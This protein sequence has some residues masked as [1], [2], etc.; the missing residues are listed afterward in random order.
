M[1]GILTETAAH[2][3]ATPRVYDPANFPER[4]GNGIPV[5]E[6][7]VFYQRPWMGGRWGV[8]EA[9]DYMMTVDFAILDTAVARRENLLRKAWE[10]A[11][12]NI[13]AGSEGGPFA[14][15]VPETGN[16][17]EMLQRLRLAGVEVRR[18]TQ[19]FT[20]NGKSFASGTWVIPAAQAFRGYIVDLMEPQRYPELRAGITGPTKK[21]YDVAGWTLPMLMG[22]GYERV[23]KPFPAALDSAEPAPVS[24]TPFSGRKWPRIALYQPWQPNMDT[25]WTQWVFDRLQIPYTLV[26]N[27]DVR[28]GGLQSRFDTIV[29]ASQSVSSILHGYRT[30]ENAVQGASGI[31]ETAAPQRPEFTG[32]IGVTGAA[33]LDEFVRDGGRLVA[34]DAAADLPVGLFGLPVRPLV[35]GTDSSP[36]GYYCPG[37]ILRLTVDSKEVFAFS[38]GGQA[39]EVMLLPSED[40]GERQVRVVA[41]YASKDVLASGWLSGERVI[42]GR[43]AL[44]EVPHGKGRV[45]LFGF[46]PQFRGQ[47]WGTFGLLVD[48][49]GVA[50]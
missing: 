34:M 45:V 14:Y 28:K 18:A 13:V 7:T 40:K 12:A 48:S 27:D 22:V 33:G 35:T 41:R 43:P 1:H 42:A 9:I 24:T 2:V 4:F 31:G 3:Y 19:P 47:T 38:S 17:L 8:R 25:G 37:S 29:F 16:A 36:N 44:L 46:R 39:W 15:V 5:K 49:L 26:H 30:G 10:T 20:A 11:R 23:D 6:S 50:R 21:P 32:G